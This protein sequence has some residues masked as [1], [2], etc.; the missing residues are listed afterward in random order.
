MGYNN[1]I[2]YTKRKDNMV[3]DALSGKY[4]GGISLFYLSLPMLG[5]LGEVCEE[6][7]ADAK[8]A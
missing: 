2:I 7:L 8:I 6:R 5:C 4:E 1:W 3:V